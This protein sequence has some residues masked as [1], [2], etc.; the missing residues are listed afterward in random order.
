MSIIGKKLYGHSI[1]GGRNLLG[2]AYLDQIKR[3][4]IKKKLLIFAFKGIQDIYTKKITGCEIFG[5]APNGASFSLGYTF[6]FIYYQ[7]SCAPTF[8]NYN[9]FIP[10]KSSGYW[11]PTVLNDL[12]HFI[13]NYLSMQFTCFI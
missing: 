12:C 13:S 5:R 6:S 7:L 4:I 11:G 2:I 9:H 10:P 3:I 1:L 8:S